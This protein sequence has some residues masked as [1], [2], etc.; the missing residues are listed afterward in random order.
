MPHRIR[1]RLPHNALMPQGGHHRCVPDGRRPVCAR[2]RRITA[3]RG[4]G[5]DELD[6]GAAIDEG[7]FDPGQRLPLSRR[8]AGVRT[9]DVDLER[10][11]DTPDGNLGGQR[12]RSFRCA[13]S[14][15]RTILEPPMTADQMRRELAADVL[16]LRA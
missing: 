13:M 9:R 14:A 11:A 16:R 4:P 10:Q 12:D 3:E 6:D 8:R 1:V 15:I 5:L 7:G 2:W